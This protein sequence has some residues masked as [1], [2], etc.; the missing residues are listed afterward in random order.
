M[1]CIVNSFAALGVA[2]IYICLVMI[3]LSWNIH[4]LGSSSKRRELRNLV[5]MANVDFLI[6][7]ETKAKSFSQGTLRSIGGGRL[8]RWELLPT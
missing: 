8:N 2:V 1:P 3:I 4:G 6:V 5:R 7:F